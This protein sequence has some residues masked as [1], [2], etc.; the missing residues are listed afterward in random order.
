MDTEIVVT[1]IREIGI[2][3]I[4]GGIVDFASARSV[5]TVEVMFGWGCNLGPDDLWVRIP[6]PLVSLTSLVE[7]KSRLGIFQFGESDLYVSTGQFEFKICH[8]GDLHFKSEDGRLIVEVANLWKEFGHTVRM[9]A[10][11]GDPR[12]LRKM[13][14]FERWRLRVRVT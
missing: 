9:A 8:E 10:D 4:F 12:V 14:R 2:E 13:A 11:T 6:V 7:E 5:N 1:G 3:R